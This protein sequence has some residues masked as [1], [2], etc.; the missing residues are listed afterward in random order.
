MR[1]N[2]SSDILSAITHVESEGHTPGMF[3]IQFDFLVFSVFVKTP[4]NQ[5]SSCT[6]CPAIRS[7]SNTSQT[8]F[9]AGSL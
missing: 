5:P 4:F 8:F 2:R 9:R 1:G 3:R 7:L 6:P